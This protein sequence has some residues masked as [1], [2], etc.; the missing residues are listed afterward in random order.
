M[1]ISLG[2]EGRIHTVD[3]AIVFDCASAVGPGRKQELIEGALR[4]VEHWCSGGFVIHASCVEI[5][6]R[7]VAFLGRAGTGK[8]TLTAGL[9]A[10]GAQLISDG[11]TLVDP[12]TR[13]V[14]LGPARCKLLEESIQRLGIDNAGPYVNESRR[15]RFVPLEARRT[16][17]EPTLSVGYVLTDGTSEFVEELNAQERIRELL[18]HDYLA[19]LLPNETQGRTLLNVATLLRSGLAL[20]RL[21]R[22]KE[23]EHLSPLMQV[24]FA[25]LA[26]TERLLPSVAHEIVE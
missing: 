13:R 4:A 11:M 18:T 5:H 8:S 9:I 2:A 1:D 17:V 15:K 6:G 22:R 7:V 10:E 14:E 16:H 21:H 20:K 26:Y 12:K 24:V 19:R 23:W 25:D 3:G